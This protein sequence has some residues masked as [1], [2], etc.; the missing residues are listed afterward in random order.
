MAPANVIWKKSRNGRRYPVCRACSLSHVIASRS[1]RMEGGA[2][3]RAD[4]EWPITRGSLRTLVAID[5]SEQAT[6]ETVANDT[7]VA[8]YSTYTLFQRLKAL[9]LIA[10]RRAAVPPAR[11]TYRLTGDGK[12]VLEAMRTAAT[13][14]GPRMAARLGWAG[15]LRGS[16]ERQR[17]KS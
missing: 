11:A 9:G 12:L 17:H 10:S 14:I 6:S 3:G 16:R 13:R 2:V 7:G 15:L 5:S 1:K 4:R 8:V